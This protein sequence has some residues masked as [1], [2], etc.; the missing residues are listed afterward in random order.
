MNDITVYGESGNAVG[1]VVVD[2]CDALP[3]KLL[4]LKGHCRIAYCARFRCYI[5]PYLRRW[6]LGLGITLF[7]L[8]IFAIVIDDCEYF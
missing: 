4:T 6:M 5:N 3:F 2:G 7:K 1:K 8:F